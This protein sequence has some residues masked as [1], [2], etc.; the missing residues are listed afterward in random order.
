MPATILRDLG[1]I[2]IFPALQPEGE[3]VQIALIDGAPVDRL[4]FH[5]EFV[6]IDI[7][8]HRLVLLVKG[9]EGFERQS[10]LIVGE[11]HEQRRIDPGSIAGQ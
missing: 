2:R 7:H 8:L 11:L 10:E 6:G 4:P 1:R 3:P 5:V 9:A